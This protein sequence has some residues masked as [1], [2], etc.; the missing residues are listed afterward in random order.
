MKLTTKGRYA[1]M[2]MADLASYSGK[3][4]ISLSE[5]SIRQNISLSY[6]EQLFF[7]L[8][9]KNLVKSIRGSNGGY[10]LDKPAS[11]I[12]IANII[13]AVD[14]K[15]KTLNCKKDSKKGC[16]NKSTKCITHNLWDELEQHINNFFE[17][18]KL[19]DLVKQNKKYN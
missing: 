6:L 17:K 3:K 9:N 12:K 2:A 8:K 19:E 7:K 4:P 18:V 15:V 13:S 1:V 5:I 16:N 10:I 14:E 11:E